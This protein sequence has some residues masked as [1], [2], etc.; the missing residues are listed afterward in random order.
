MIDNLHGVIVDSAFI[1]VVDPQGKKVACDIK[2]VFIVRLARSQHTIVSCYQRTH[3][4]DARSD[5]AK[6]P[7]S[8]VQNIEANSPILFNICHKYD[9]LRDG[10]VLKFTGLSEVAVTHEMSNECI[11]ICGKFKSDELILNQRVT[12]TKIGVR[13]YSNVR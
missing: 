10:Q 4:N 9:I 12:K 11:V 2:I 1:G 8:P 6:T 5:S 13:M 3:R 7:I